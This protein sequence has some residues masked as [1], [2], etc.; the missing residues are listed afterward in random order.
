MDFI[1][2][3]R[4]VLRPD[5]AVTAQPVIYFV[6]AVVPWFSPCV[7]WR[8]CASE[9]R[10]KRDFDWFVSFLIERWNR[11]SHSSLGST[12]PRRFVRRFLHIPSSAETVFWWA[13]TCDRWDRFLSQQ[14]PSVFSFHH[15]RVRISVSFSYHVLGREMDPRHDGAEP[16]MRAAQCF[17]TFALTGPTLS[18]FLY[19]QSWRHEC[20]EPWTMVST[21]VKTADGPNVFPTYAAWF[22][23][24][25]DSVGFFSSGSAYV[26]S[27]S[28]STFVA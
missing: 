8:I 11:L 6:G 20:A 16:T 24:R 27:R 4:V 14:P 10:R 1:L 13:W 25:E 17:S 5:Q 21:W 12:C 19:F 18:S 2:I 9:A 28:V 7:I 26:A 15:G 23:T 3:Q 22:Q